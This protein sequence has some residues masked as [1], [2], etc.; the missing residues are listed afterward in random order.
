MPIVARK[1]EFIPA[2]IRVRKGELLILQFTAPEVPMGANFADFG[3][4]ADLVPG[5]VRKA[6]IGPDK[7]CPFAFVCDTVFCARNGRGTVGG[8]LVV[9]GSRS[10]VMEKSEALEPTRRRVRDRQPGRRYPLRGTQVGWRRT[11]RQRKRSK[12]ASLRRKTCSTW[13]A[14]A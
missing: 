14:A 5:Q 12:R 8:I 7:A 11:W 3:V 9:T 4:R 10:C 6:Q 2:E 1:F 13:T